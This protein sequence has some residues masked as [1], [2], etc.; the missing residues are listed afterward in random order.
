MIPGSKGLHHSHRRKRVHQLNEK[1]PHPDKYK[2]FMDKAIYVV[3]IF[4]PIMTIPQLTKIWVYKNAQG[5][6]V[7]S[8]FAYLITA[9]F[10]LTYGIMH[11]EKPIIF[12]NSI[13]IILEIFIII[14]TILYG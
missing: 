2:A 7:I 10:W 9:L 12:T 4:G 3:C 5:I 1:Y 8:W 14:G 6:S 11:K 13:W